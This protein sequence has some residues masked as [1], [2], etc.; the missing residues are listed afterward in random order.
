[1]PAIDFYFGPGSRYSYLA[2]VRISALERETGATIRWRAVYSPDLIKRA[3]SDPFAPANRRGQYDPAYRTRDAGRW[4]ELFGIAYT[5]PDF[6]ALDSRSVA[7]WCV[8]AELMDGGATFG[9]AA[10]SAVFA[11][12]HMPPTSAHLERI[13]HEVG[14]NAGQLANLVETGAAAKAHEQNIQDALSAGA[15][16]VP[17]FVTDDGE[18]FWGQDRMPLLVHHLLHRRGTSR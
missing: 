8:A 5:E 1:M 9:V 13:A 4:A 3:G 17:T 2:A 15:F 10:L 14:L 18:L 11:S 12:G 7:L 6:A 16:G